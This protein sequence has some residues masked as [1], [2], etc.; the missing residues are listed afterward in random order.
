MF[1]YMK[2][3]VINVSDERW[4]KYK[5][6][7]RYIR[8]KGVVG[9]EL[10]LETYDKYVFYYNK[11]ESSKRSAIGCSESHLSL[12][13]YIYENKLN[14]CI[15]IEDDALIDFNRLDE[16]KDVK[17]FSYI[18]GRFQA[19]ILKNDNLFQKEFNKEIFSTQKLNKINPN[20]FIIIGAHGYYFENYN[21]VKDIFEDIQ[22]QKRQ[23]AIDVE[24]KRIQKKRPDLI[25]QFIFPAICTLYLPDAQNGFTYNN[26][27][28]WK[29]KDNNYLY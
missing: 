21:V 15:V 13:K 24:L 3:F 2:V 16:L 9:Q 18:G 14:N 25:N 22:S 4:E 29:L 5:A 8:F 6:D 26:K 28:S 12:M 1:L 10:D 19:P 23:R 11:N 27:S 17:G 7:T 20:E